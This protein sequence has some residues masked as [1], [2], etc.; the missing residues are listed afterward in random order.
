MDKDLSF[1][2]QVLAQQDDGERR[3]LGTGVLIAPDRVLTCKHLVMERDPCG[4]PTE[5]THQEL[6]VNAEGSGPAVNV[7]SVVFHA[8]LDLAIL[9]LR[10]TLSASP[11]PFLVSV[12]EQVESQLFHLPWHVWA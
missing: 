8:E 7:K 6:R 12:T 9:K 1:I 5:I 11:P 10:S 2:V 4:N 3:F